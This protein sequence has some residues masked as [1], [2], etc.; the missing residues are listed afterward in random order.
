MVHPKVV[1]EVFREANA[2][3]LLNSPDLLPI[4]GM[5]YNKI[6]NM[7]HIFMPQK[8]SLYEYLH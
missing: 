3:R 6:S 2:L 4:E 5:C 1:D 8:I 7:M